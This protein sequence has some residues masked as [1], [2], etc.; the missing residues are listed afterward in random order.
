MKTTDPIA[1]P[2]R[3]GET[4]S[5]LHGETLSALHDGEAHDLELRRLLRDLHRGDAESRELTDTWTRLQLTRS[6]M[7]GEPLVPAAG[8]LAGVQAAI[9]AEP[10]AASTSPWRRAA[11]SFAVAASMAALVVLG[12]QQLGSSDATGDGERV[13][14]LPVGVVNTTGAVPV[15]ASLGARAVPVL[16]P[17]DRTAYRELARQRLSRYSQEHAE[18]ASLNTPQGLVPFAR[19]PVIE[20]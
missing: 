2:P 14:P 17:A 15:R 5:A 12:G 6:A 13:A 11:G 20:P 4:L 16:Q 3:H 18:H 9:D 19:V 8:L 1:G 10:Q 7:Q